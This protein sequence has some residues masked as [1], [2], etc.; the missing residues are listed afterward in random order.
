MTLL[1]LT[2]TLEKVVESLGYLLQIGTVLPDF[3][4]TR[5]EVAPLFFFN[6]KVLGFEFLF[7]FLSDFD[8]L[9]EEVVDLREHSLLGA[10]DLC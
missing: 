2:E 6:Q 3:I 9:V 8:Y 5:C 7:S 1:T 10:I 4:Q